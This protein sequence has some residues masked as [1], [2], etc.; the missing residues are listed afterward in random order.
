MTKLNE[1]LAVLQQELQS[2]RD[3]VKEVRKEIEHC[4]EEM[5]AQNQEIAKRVH[6]K[7][8]KE[9]QVTRIFSFISAYFEPPITGL[10]RL[11]CR[12]HEMN[13]FFPPLFTNIAILKKEYFPIHSDQ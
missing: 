10:R 9:S 6:E 13:V 4:K 5:A 12:Q 1:Q 2:E 11:H 8:Q 3:Q 7:E